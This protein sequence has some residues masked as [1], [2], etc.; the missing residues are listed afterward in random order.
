MNHRLLES[1]WFHMSGA[2][3]LWETLPDP[4]MPGLCRVRTAEVVMKVGGGGGDPPPFLQCAVLHLP[5]SSISQTHSSKGMWQ[6]L[7]AGRGKHPHVFQGT[8]QREG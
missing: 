3:W 7:G 8:V 6:V 1:L 4:R 5:S 2:A